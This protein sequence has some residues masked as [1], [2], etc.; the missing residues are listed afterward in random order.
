[1]FI[2]ILTHTPIW[3]FFLFIFLLIFGFM[4]TRNRTVSRA[5]A[6]LLPIGMVALSLAG[7]RS[8]F[9]LVTL[10][11]ATWGAALLATASIGYLLFRDKRISYDK[12]N[13]KFYIPGSWLSFAVIM[14]IFF[15]KYVFAVMR[16]FNA[17]II[18]E[19][20]FIGTL[21]V[22]YGLFSGY[23]ASRAVN[24]IAQAQKA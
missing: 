17:T 24:L 20:V 9:G 10:P 4:Q 18:S 7:I 22:A 19:P 16:A 3:V 15:T 21:C 1:M 6:L 14:A 23:F 12:Q 2:Q 5:P 13:K 11:V 8:S